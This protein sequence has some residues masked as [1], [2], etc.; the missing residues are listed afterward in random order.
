MFHNRCLSLCASLSILYVRSLGDAVAH[1]A[2][3]SSEAEIFD[4]K[5]DLTKDKFLV[6]A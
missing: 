2:G 1:T 4:R 6:R 3:V 5:I